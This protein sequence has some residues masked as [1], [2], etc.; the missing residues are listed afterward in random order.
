[1]NKRLL[2][3]V[4]GALMLLLSVGTLAANAAEGVQA[5]GQTATSEQQASA[6]SGATQ[7]DPS[8]TNIDVRVLSPGDNGAVSRTN[9]ATWESTAWNSDETDQDAGA[10]Q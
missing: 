4:V 1:M 7:V 2:A 5:D 10:N 3:C 8:N 9:A 6:A